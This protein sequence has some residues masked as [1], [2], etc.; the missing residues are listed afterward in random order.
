MEKIETEFILSTILVLSFAYLNY[1]VRRRP[2]I[3]RIV[4]GFFLIIFLA[5]YIPMLSL[6]V[7]H[8]EVVGVTN[9][10]GSVK[11]KS[12]HRYIMFMYKYKNKF[13]EGGNS[14]GKKE[15][16]WYNSKGSRFVVLV[17]PWFPSGG[18]MDFSR[19]VPDSTEVLS[20]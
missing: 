1:S 15:I 18:K 5:M 7:Y 10:I 17:N 12:A 11:G 19:P 6:Q 14:P 16:Y 13:Y 3:D 9:G 2:L 20:K 4:S 8:E